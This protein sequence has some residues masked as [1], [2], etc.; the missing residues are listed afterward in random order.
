M[1]TV[2][3]YLMHVSTKNRREMNMYVN[4]NGG[5]ILRLKSDI[6]LFGVARDYLYAARELKPKDKIYAFEEV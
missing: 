4:F 1:I 2:F 3:K 5:N 6:V